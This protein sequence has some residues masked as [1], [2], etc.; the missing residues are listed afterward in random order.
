MAAHTITTHAT[1][2]KAA[3]VRRACTQ[4]RAAAAN[5]PIANTKSACAYE[6]SVADAGCHALARSRKR[7]A[8]YAIHP[9]AQASRYFFRNARKKSRLTTTTL[10]AAVSRAV[11]QVAKTP[12]DCASSPVG[13]VNRRTSGKPFQ[14]QAL[15]P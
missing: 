2:A 6:A 4:L 10:R 15:P 11:S 8:V 12:T 3:R 13:P 9:A 14:Y 5:N 1:A 7:N